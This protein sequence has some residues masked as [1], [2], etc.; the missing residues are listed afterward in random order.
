MRFSEHP[1]WSRF[2]AL[3][4]PFFL[5]EVR[6]K[7]IGGFLLLA[8]LLW[9][10]AGWYQAYR[11]RLASEWR[12]G[13]WPVEPGAV[14]TREQLVRAFEHLALLL[15]GLPART[16]NHEELARGMAG[17]PATRAEDARELAAA[18]EQ[19]RYAPPQD[20]LSDD[21]LAAARR[22]LASLA[23]SSAA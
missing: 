5:S 21:R 17:L 11:A 20:E 3:A 13:P 12:L 9:R 7:A 10:G 4:W 15:F 16:M 23:G 8:V 18:Y 2:T 6:T 14:R 22:Q 1:L 19:A